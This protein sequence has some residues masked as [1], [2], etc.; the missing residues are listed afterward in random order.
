MK[1]T[2]TTHQ[3]HYIKTCLKKF[4]LFYSNAVHTPMVNTRLSVKDQPTEVDVETL[5]LYREMVGSC[6]YISSWTRPDIACV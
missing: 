6:L 2:V 3:Q 4:G 1:G 5:A